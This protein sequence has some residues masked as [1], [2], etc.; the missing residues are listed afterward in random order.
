MHLHIKIEFRCGRISIYFLL[1]PLALPT[2]SLPGKAKSRPNDRDRDF[3]RY[4]RRAG[5]ILVRRRCQEGR[6]GAL[7]QNDYQTLECL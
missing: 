6:R 3:R 1:F 2:A 5:G 7:A 4:I